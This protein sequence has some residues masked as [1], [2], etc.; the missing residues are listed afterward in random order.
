MTYPLV[1]PRGQNAHEPASE[2]GEYLPAAHSVHDDEAACEYFPA[3]QD[4]HPDTSELL[5]ETEYLPLEQSPQ[6]IYP[7]SPDGQ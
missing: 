1:N 7:Y 6:V 2:D 5:P 3:V 4:L